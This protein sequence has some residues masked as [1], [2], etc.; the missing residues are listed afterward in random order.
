MRCHRTRCCDNICL[1]TAA[2]RHMLL[3]TLAG[4]KRLRRG[5]A[6]LA[7]VGILGWTLLAATHWHDPFEGGGPSQ[8][9]AAQCLLCLGTA[10]GAPPPGISILHLLAAPLAMPVA[11]TAPRVRVFAALSSYQSRAPPAI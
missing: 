11:D 7:C 5:V 6:L 2:N 3:S 4:A 8:H 10:T 1:M 9:E